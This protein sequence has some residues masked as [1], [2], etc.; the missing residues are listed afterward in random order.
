[1]R[2]Y[3]ARPHDTWRPVLTSVRPLVDAR[4][5]LVAGAGSALVRVGAR[6]LC[7][8]DDARAALWIEPGSGAL[9]PLPLG[10]S[11][12][13]LAKRTKPDF[14]AAFVAG[15]ELVVLGSGSAPGRAAVVYAPLD[16]RP[17]REVD[18]SALY[19]TLAARLGAVLNLEGAVLV[20]S[21]RGELVRLFHRAS[22]PE[23]GASATFDVELGALRCGAGPVLDEARYDLG[24][25]LGVPLAFTD[26]ALLPDGRIAFLAAAE[27]TVDPVEDGAVLGTV[28]GVLDPDGPRVAP[29][30]ELDG[31]P[32]R[33]KLE[34]LALDADGRGAYSVT[35]P[36]DVER[37]AEL[38]RLEWLAAI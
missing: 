2:R 8:Q 21:A 38:C 32:T 17:V 6:L 25:V 12:A 4:S 23:R 33:R 1:M 13:R 18:A 3:T 15:D 9:E 31:S 27:D 24:G 14:E 26:A 35:D 16:G 7:V 5:G 20:S 28:L 37:P 34:G 36:D 19:A 11:T 22:S 30:V 29:I 10:G